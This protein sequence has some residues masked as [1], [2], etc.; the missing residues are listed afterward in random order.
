MRRNGARNKARKVKPRH[1]LRLGC[2]IG[3][4]RAGVLAASLGASA[5][6]GCSG[7]D[8]ATG[9]LPLLK[10]ATVALPGNTSRM[11]YTSLDTRRHRLFI[12]HL[13]QGEI[14]VVDTN[15]RGVLARIPAPDV[16]GVLAVP[17]LGKVY[18]TA[19]DSAQALTID[20]D[21]LQVIA[22]THTGGTPDGFSYD[23]ADHR[24]FVSDETGDELTV[25]EAASGLAIGAVKL[26]GEVGNNS[27]DPASGR[28][29]ALDQTHNQLDVINPMTLA[30][31]AR[32]HLGNCDHSHSLTLDS[33]TRRAF[34]ACD[35]NN[36]LLTVDLDTFGETDH[37]A[38]G[39]G[40]D[41]LALDP[42]LNRL[43]VAA[44][45]GTWTVFDT[46]NRHT[47][48]IARRHLA[49]D[50]HTLAV[51][52]TT[53]AVYVPLADHGGHPVLEVLIPT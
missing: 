19:S 25:L 30:V 44:E 6:T 40:P 47:R 5:L 2:G 24:V 17:Q 50:A 52:D 53:H 22:R 4:V 29:L 35:G 9:T 33:L 16:H 10:T 38:T 31:I 23:S 45:S 13:G 8:G 15:T 20:T 42:G 49:A 21:T 3:S 7:S 14:I 28:I 34:V 26:G 51:D 12:A 43:Y 32:H 46:A 39:A 36:Q 1:R 48:L 37:T 11:D 27:Y 18:A 41:V